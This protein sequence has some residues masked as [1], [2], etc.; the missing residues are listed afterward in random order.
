MSASESLRFGHVELFPSQFCFA[1]PLSP[2]DFDHYYYHNNQN[3]N[4]NYR[5]ATILNNHF[6]SFYSEKAKPYEYVYVVL[7][8]NYHH[9]I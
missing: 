8:Y 5:Y 7:L 1:A 2:F 4:R 9:L 6:S 3:Y